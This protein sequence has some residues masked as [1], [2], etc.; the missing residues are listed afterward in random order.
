MYQRRTY[1]WVCV[2]R[3]ASERND[4]EKWSEAKLGWGRS[5]EQRRTSNDKD[6]LK[7]KH[8]ECEKLCV[9]VWTLNGQSSANT[10]QGKVEYKVMVRHDKMRRSDERKLC[11]FFC[12]LV[13]LVMWCLCICNIQK[14][15]SKS[16][17]MGINAMS[18]RPKMHSVTTKCRRQ[19]VIWVHTMV[20]EADRRKISQI[21]RVRVIRSIYVGAYVCLFRWCY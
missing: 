6:I 12:C 4:S 18:E 19:C 1:P 20:R 3:W 5:R 9:C 11:I 16:I 14:C 8:S 2:V 10:R 7:R 13:S 15:Q 17:I 21:I